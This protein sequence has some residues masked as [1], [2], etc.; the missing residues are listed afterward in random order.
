VP[1][2]E[3]ESLRESDRVAEAA[4]IALILAGVG[5]IVAAWLWWT[6]HG[7]FARLFLSFAVV[8]SV[9]AVCFWIAR[10]VL[11]QLSRVRH[12]W[13]LSLG[14]TLVAVAGVAGLAAIAWTIAW[15]W[16]EGLSVINRL[17]SADPMR[18]YIQ[19]LRVADNV[20]HLSFHPEIAGVG[21]MRSEAIDITSLRSA[22]VAGSAIEQ[23]NWRTWMANGA[24]TGRPAAV[25]AP[26]SNYTF[27]VELA[28]VA[29]EERGV[30]TARLSSALRAALAKSVAAGKPLNLTTVL[31]TDPDAL[32]VAQGETISRPLIID[33]DALREPVALNNSWFS[34]SKAAVASLGN[35]EYRV[36]T[37]SRAGWTSAAV[38]LIKDN[39]ALDQ[40]IAQFCVSKCGDSSPPAGT[41]PGPA[42]LAALLEDS[43]ESDGS[44]FL[45]ELEPNRLHGVLVLAQP[46]NGQHV[47]TW[48]VAR[49]GQS[50]YEYLRSTIVAQFRD[51]DTRAQLLVKGQALADF[52]FP[53]LSDAEAAQRAFETFVS[54]RRPSLPDR[55]KGLARL[56][57][58]FDF[59]PVDQS[60]VILPMGLLVV[61]TAQG[62][63]F[64][65]RH[66]AIEQPLSRAS[67]RQTSVCPS[68]WVALVPNGGAETLRLAEAALRK[69]GSDWVGTSGLEVYNDLGLFRNWLRTGG[70]Q[71]SST[72]LVLSHHD[73]N[74]LFFF[75][76]DAVVSPN[77]RSHYEAPS[78][79]ILSGCGTGQPGAVDFVEQFNQHGFDG[80]IVS[81]F[82]V[83]PAVAGAYAGC[84]RQHSEVP[85]TGSDLAYVHYEAINN[86]S[87]PTKDPPLLTEPGTTGVEELTSELY[88]LN[89]LKFTL[90]GNSNLRICPVP[91][92]QE[93]EGK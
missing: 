5:L 40:I 78:I 76:E 81:S 79:V 35:V 33:V 58:K 6:G 41:V 44:L 88:A 83:H 56:F 69:T 55:R 10:R 4:R 84:F 27:H 2:T 85:G 61:K 53:A 68:R 77:I 13:P 63:D 45:T 37:K 91:N 80:A 9:L 75:P 92:A 52:I 60:L 73:R 51:L 65:G 71:P 31:I 16:E 66:V 90:V 57:V 93:T 36:R 1:N 11:A 7:F 18:V 70:I 14:S 12:A 47:W 48:S 86:C 38:L 43:Q 59:R 15:N 89:A 82:D 67:Y 34:V 8:G 3:N 30:A 49:S 22:V 26:T 28:R 32:D 62:D 17:L 21:A 23:L 24:N 42:T 19:N 72:L 29:G 39:R 46:Q 25:L 20:A 54:V 74:Q 50:F 64:L 87:W